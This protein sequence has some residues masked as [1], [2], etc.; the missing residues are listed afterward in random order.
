MAISTEGNP[1]ERPAE[2]EAPVADAAQEP[3]TPISSQANQPE[4]PSEP[5]APV[6]DPTKT[7]ATP[8]S[9]EGTQ[10]PAEAG[11]A[12]TDAPK[13]ATTPALNDGNGNQAG[14]PAN[15]QPPAPDGPGTDGQGKD[16]SEQ[17][18]GSCIAGALRCIG[19]VLVTAYLTILYGLLVYAQIA[20]WH[21][22]GEMVA[23][24]MV[25]APPG[26]TSFAVKGDLWLLIVVLTVG[27]LGSF[28]HTATSFADYVGN[29][30][31]QRSWVVWFML[32]P[33]IG[34]ALALILYLTLRGGL[35]GSTSDAQSLNVYGFA[36]IAALSGMFSKQATDKLREVFDTL[37]RTS[38]DAARGDKLK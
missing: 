31:A 19:I 28:I 10:P 3:G 15:T 11:A 27:A 4:R 8:I 12:A 32:R 9:D 1:A 35:L 25:I 18:A 34:S 22:A 7:P 36:A 6:A 21:G 23:E 14:R 29:M 37:F 30:R 38:G 2:P 5:E 20:L 16:P 26:L 13:A 24:D 17:G 33:F